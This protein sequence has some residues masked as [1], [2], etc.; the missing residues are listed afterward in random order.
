M[1]IINI[2]WL[3]LLPDA[4]KRFL[5]EV[6]FSLEN[7]VHTVE[8][9]TCWHLYLYCTDVSFSSIKTSFFH[10][11]PLQGKPTLPS[12][13]QR[14]GFFSFR[15]RLFILFMGIPE[16]TF[17]SLIQFTHQLKVSLQFTGEVFNTWNTK[18]EAAVHSPFQSITVTTHWARLHVH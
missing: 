11:F 14:F 18:A 3:D 16:H 17:C 9:W 8:V 5:W 4:W 12:T 1:T 2:Y 7:T 10:V 15:W 6:K 13:P